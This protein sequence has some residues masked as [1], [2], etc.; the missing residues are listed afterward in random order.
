[1]TFSTRGGRHTHTREAKPGGKGSYL[2]RTQREGNQDM[3]FAN[4][5]K[6]VNL[7]LSKIWNKNLLY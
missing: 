2:V 3:T 1:M 4:L 7:F 6:Q 5:N